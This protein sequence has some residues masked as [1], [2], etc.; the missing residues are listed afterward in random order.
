M[1]Q[2]G[3][4]PRVPPGWPARKGRLT[5]A[6]VDKRPD[7]T[8]RA[9]WREYPSGP[10][11]TKHFTRKVDAEHHLVKVQHDLMT[12]AYVDPSKGRTTVQAY[13]EAWSARQPWRESSR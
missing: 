2:R 12:G 5:M 1:G 8:W 3:P 7:G 11:K 6:S 10:Q 13:Y 9:R 4:A